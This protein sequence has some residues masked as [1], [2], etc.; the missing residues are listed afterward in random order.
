MPQ[1]FSRN[2]YHF[3]TKTEREQSHELFYV[4]SSIKYMVI[5]ELYYIINFLMAVQILFLI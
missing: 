3:K 5:H 4:V 2:I 1:G